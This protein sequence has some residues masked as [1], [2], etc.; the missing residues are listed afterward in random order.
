MLL[1][2][3]IAATIASCTVT[4]ATVRADAQSSSARTITLVAILLARNDAPAVEFNSCCHLFEALSLNAEPC[5][6]FSMVAGLRP[7]NSKQLPPNYE[8]VTTMLRG[9][10]PS[11]PT[12]TSTFKMRR[13]SRYPGTPA[14]SGGELAATGDRA[15]TPKTA[16]LGTLFGINDRGCPP[17]ADRVFAANVARVTDTVVPCGPAKVST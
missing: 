5:G 15:W 16:P 10:W 7:M 17:Y 8:E 9:L 2:L 6:R 13:M 12:A 4:T 3:A 11:A 1:R 14:G